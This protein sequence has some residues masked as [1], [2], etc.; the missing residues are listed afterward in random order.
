MFVKEI[1]A[2]EGIMTNEIWAVLQCTTDV[3]AIYFITTKTVLLI[4]KQR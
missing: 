3:S 2:E 1:Q 4:S